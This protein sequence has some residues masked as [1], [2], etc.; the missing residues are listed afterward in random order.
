MFLSEIISS[1]DDTRTNDMNVPEIT[2]AI[3]PASTNEQRIGDESTASPEPVELFCLC[4]RE[5]FGTMIQ[6]DSTQCQT[7]WYH[8]DCVGM[9]KKPAAK[10]R[11]Y[12]SA[13]LLE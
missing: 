10:K 2:N 12:C 3:A 5:S 11:W 6:C 8:M 4:R 9:T 13:C 7:K 1:A